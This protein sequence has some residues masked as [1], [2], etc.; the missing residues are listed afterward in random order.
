MYP[1]E[2]SYPFYMLL[3]T[4]GSDEAHDLEKVEQLLEKAV[5]DGVVVDG[6]IAQD[7]VQGT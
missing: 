6:T 7:L 5:E 2:N 3:E 4:S 1:H